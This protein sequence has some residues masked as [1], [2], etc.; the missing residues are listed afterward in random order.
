[1]P[2]PRARHEKTRL[3]PLALILPLV[4]GILGF[5]ACGGG[6]KLDAAQCRVIRGKA[7]N[8][9]GNEAALCSSD[10]DC[11]LSTWPGC[12]RASNQKNTDA[13]KPI[14]DEWDKGKCEEEK[15]PTCPTPPEGA[16][17][18]QGVCEEKKK[19]SPTIE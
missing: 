12:P 18:N 17:C 5:A 6:D 8:I 10:K 16:I 11:M 4:A 15:A 13:I 14:K 2:L 7:F 1:M 3:R 19:K 9:L